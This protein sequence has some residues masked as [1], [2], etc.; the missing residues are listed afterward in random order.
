MTSVGLEI[1]FEQS[2]R[3]IRSFPEEK[4]RIDMMLAFQRENMHIQRFQ[5]FGIF[6][7]ARVVIYLQLVRGHRCR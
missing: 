2:L 7:E 3:I 5:E 6:G 1:M 4:L